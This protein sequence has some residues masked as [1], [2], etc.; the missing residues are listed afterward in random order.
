MR[1]RAVGGTSGEQSNRHWDDEHA[2]R[3]YR[4]DVEAR[5][6]PGNGPGKDPGAW[7]PGPP[8]QPTSSHHGRRHGIKVMRIH[9]RGQPV[10]HVGYQALPQAPWPFLDVSGGF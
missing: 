6:Q 4:Q 2:D 10:N 3:C 1:P 7:P 9:G 8:P 5:Q